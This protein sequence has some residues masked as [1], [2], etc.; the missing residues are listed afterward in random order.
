[1]KDRAV[2]VL[3]SMFVIMFLLAGTALPTKVIKAA[4]FS[5]SVNATTV[6]VGSPI[7]ITVRADGLT[8]QIFYTGAYEDDVWIENETKTVG[9]IYINEPGTYYFGV[10]GEL[11][12]S[13]TAQDNVY[14]QG[15]NIRVIAQEVME[16]DPIEY[17]SNEDQTQDQGVEKIELSSISTL[18]S[19]SLSAGKLEPA[20]S[21][22]VKEYKVN[23]DAETTTLNIKASASDQHAN[24]KGDGEIKLHV[25]DNKIDVTCIA[26]DGSKT[27]YTIRAHVDDRPLVFVNYGDKKLGVS[28][29]SKELTKKLFE[30]TTIKVGGKETQAW[31]NEAK[32]LTLLYLEDGKEKNFYFYDSKKEEV[33]SIYRPLALA[34]ENVAMIDVPFELQK[35][36]GMI[37]GTVEVD[38]EKLPGWTYEDPAFSNY[39]QIYVMNDAG[40]CVYYQYEKTQESMQLF[41]GKAALSQEQY[42]K[43]KQ[44]YNDELKKNEQKNMIIVGGAVI[45]ALCVVIGAIIMKKR[46]TKATQK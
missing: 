33:T 26:E 30:K 15:V 4:S 41:D 28:R 46:N 32:N 35:R 14:S 5:M 39:V 1:M 9:P 18:D 29:Y 36:E 22:K 25:G 19:L 45:V 44:A 16:D 11:A 21:S 43:L 27:V 38:G 23:L 42:T 7:Y 24:V 34:G 3:K 8:G 40:A 6:Y 20:F 17:P 37:F 12:N 10:N 31:V 13:Q 2:R